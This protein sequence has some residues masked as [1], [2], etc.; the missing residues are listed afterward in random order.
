MFSESN[1]QCGRLC[2]SN[3]SKR[4]VLPRN[5]T[6]KS[7]WTRFYMNVDHPEP[8]K[9]STGDH[10]HYFYYV[11][12]NHDR[13]IVYDYDGEPYEDCVK[14]AIHVREKSSSLPWWELATSYTL[15]FSKFKDEER[16][17]NKFSVVQTNSEEEKEN[18]QTYSTS[19]KPDYG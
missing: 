12:G 8:E 5:A 2:E 9:T 10:E 11:K 13:L 6:I 14:K 4:S 3:R 16:I 18:D 15:L 7:G 1:T 19:L 17:K